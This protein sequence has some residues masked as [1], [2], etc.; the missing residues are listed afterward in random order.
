LA[1]LVAYDEDR[2]RRHTAPAKLS[3]LCGGQR[4]GAVGES[5][6]VV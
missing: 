4:P 2:P 5:Q 3:I 1:S 6:V